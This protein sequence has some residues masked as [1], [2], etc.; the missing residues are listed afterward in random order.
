M[1]TRSGRHAGRDGPAGCVYVQQHDIRSWHYQG[2]YWR[3]YVWS[4][5]SSR[6]PGLGGAGIKS[7]E[8]ESGASLSS[9]QMINF[10]CALPA[11]AGLILG[12]SPGRAESL[13]FKRVSVPHDHHGPPRRRVGA[14]VT[15]TVYFKFMRRLVRLRGA[16]RC[17]R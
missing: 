12:E 17:Q 7:H 9:A 1:P 13:G 10:S 16:G 6:G 14:S 11:D 4:S 5:T 2:Q 3:L 15:V 8:S